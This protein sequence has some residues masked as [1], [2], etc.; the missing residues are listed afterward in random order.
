VYITR[1]SQTKKPRLG[2]HSSNSGLRS[3]TNS[4]RGEHEESN[5]IKDPTSVRA[6]VQWNGTK[7]S[8]CVCR[9]MS[10][11]NAPRSVAGSGYI[12]VLV[13]AQ[14]CRH[15]YRIAGRRGV[16]RLGTYLHLFPC[17]HTEPKSNYRLISGTDNI[18]GPA[19]SFI[20]MY[21]HI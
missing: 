12:S 9:Q 4:A 11:G 15:R 13:L 2:P 17:H 21:V 14:T 19:S 7:G 6:C 1:H 20:L 5:R 18:G 8:A 16:H 10:S 3:F